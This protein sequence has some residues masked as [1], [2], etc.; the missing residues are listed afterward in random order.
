VIGC[1]NRGELNR[2][3]VPDL[4]QHARVVRIHVT[5]LF[6]D[7]RV[8]LRGLDDKACHLDGQLPPLLRT[9][10]DERIAGHEWGIHCCAP[11]YSH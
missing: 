4:K 11:L 9:R 5:Q 6:P 8:R 7:R 10:C 2:H 1:G 3:D